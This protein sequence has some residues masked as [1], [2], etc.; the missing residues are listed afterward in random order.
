MSG[1][2]SDRRRFLRRAGV[3]GLGGLTAAGIYP[4]LEA[5]WCRLVRRTI[6]LPNLPAAFRGTTAVLVSDVH[7]GPFVP[8]VYIR[9][10][11][12]TVNSLKPDL[13]L[14]AGDFV[15]RSSR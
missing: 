3:V 11:V 1:M 10:V 5:K 7:P 15:S 12:E 14:L 8:L 6:T 4:F 2:R 13:V 9:H